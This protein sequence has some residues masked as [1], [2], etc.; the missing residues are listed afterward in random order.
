MKLAATK[1]GTSTDGLAGADRSTW[2][3]HGTKI[4]ELWSRRPG[5]DRNAGARAAKSSG[6]GGG[7][8]G[9][10][11]GGGSKGGKH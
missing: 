5:V 7:K 3:I 9:G 4:S 1:R 11:N 8:S 10:G 6:G 2:M